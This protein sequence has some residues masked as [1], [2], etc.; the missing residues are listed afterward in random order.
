[1]AAL[2]AQLHLETVLSADCLYGNEM[3]LL[4]SPTPLHEKYL[5]LRCTAVIS[6]APHHHRQTHFIYGD[7]TSQDS[8]HYT[9]PCLSLPNIEFIVFLGIPVSYWL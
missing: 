4:P 3:G 7:H 2:Y 6:F 1:M 8:L 5:T 9:I